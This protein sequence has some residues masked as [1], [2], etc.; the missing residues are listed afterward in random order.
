[1]GYMPSPEQR[2]G[3]PG[4]EQSPNPEYYQAARYVDEQHAGEAYFQA[5]EALFATN[6]DLSAYR[7]RLEQMSYVA[8]LGD[9]PP[10]EFDQTLQAILASGEPVTLPAGI[11]Q[12]LNQRRI[13]AR[14]L[15]SWVERHYHPGKRIGG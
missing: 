2:R 1:M 10:A 9:T 15:G 5:Q 12:V 6:F 3:E 11:L 14:G 4:K 8:V 7:F 13:Q